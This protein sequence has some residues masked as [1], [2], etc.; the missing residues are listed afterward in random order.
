MAVAVRKKGGGGRKCSFQEGDAGLAGD[1]ALMHDVV[2]AACD[3]GRNEWTGKTEGHSTQVAALPP[4]NYGLFRA[5]SAPQDIQ[6]LLVCTLQQG[7][8]DFISNLSQLYQ[9]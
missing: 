9:E 6:R 2:D 7:M 1:L 5:A 8:M 4:L 3:L